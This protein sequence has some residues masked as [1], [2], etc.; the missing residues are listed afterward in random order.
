MALDSGS[1]TVR[2][3]SFTVLLGPS[4]CG[5]TTCLRI[6]AGLETATE[7]QIE[8]AGRD[9]TALP[10]ASRGVA[11][12][13]QSYALFPHLSVAC[14]RSRTLARLSVARPTIAPDAD[15]ADGRYRG[16]DGAG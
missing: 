11:M 9:V 8:I 7:G 1:L 16:F 6:V 13:F 5:K 10:T 14:A 12:V 2:P 3:G 4:G 15:R